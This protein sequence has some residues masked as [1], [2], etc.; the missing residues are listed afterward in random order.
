MCV[1]TCVCVCVCVC[2]CIKLK[3]FFQLHRQQDLP[4]LLIK[5]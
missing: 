5:K 4:K 1:Y 2:V 3:G